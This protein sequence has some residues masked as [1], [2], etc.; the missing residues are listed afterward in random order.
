MMM[1][2]VTGWRLKLRILRNRFFWWRVRVK[3]KV[4]LKYQRFKLI[5]IVG[6]PREEVEKWEKFIKEGFDDPEIKAM[7]IDIHH[8]IIHNVKERHKNGS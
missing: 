5:Y 6:V 3:S 7:I 1:V 2:E 4:N 8:A